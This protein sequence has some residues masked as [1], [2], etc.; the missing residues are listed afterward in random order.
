LTTIKWKCNDVCN[1][2]R[3]TYMLITQWRNIAVI[4]E[5]FRTKT[6]RT[7]VWC[8]ILTGIIVLTFNFLCLWTICLEG[9]R[10]VFVVYLLLSINC[11]LLC[12]V[13]NNQHAS[14]VKLIVFLLSVFVIVLHPNM[15]LANWH[16]LQLRFQT[17]N[18]GHI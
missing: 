1:F 16:G 12:K 2:K 13:H 15:M 6:I 9:K 11:L 4:P 10:V 5:H 14:K 8:N 18:G 3:Y 7:V 17:L